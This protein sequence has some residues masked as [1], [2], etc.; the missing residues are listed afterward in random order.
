MTASS[1]LQ[2]FNQAAQ[3]PPDARKK[4]PPPFSIRFTDEERARLNQ[5]AGAL[6]LAAYIRL[7]LFAGEETPPSRP[8]MTKKPPAPSLELAVLGQMLAGLG[9]SRLASNVNQLAKAANTG[10]LPVDPEVEAELR[11]ACEDIRQMRLA[12]ISALGVKAR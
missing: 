3:R 11:D 4:P 12:L 2:S 6:S 7:K 1:N 8:R 10:S 5:A 9:Q